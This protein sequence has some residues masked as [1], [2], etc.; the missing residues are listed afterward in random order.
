[1]KYISRILFT[2]GLVF[3][4]T[5][6]TEDALETVGPKLPDNGDMSVNITFALPDAEAQTRSKVS[7]T[8]NRVHTMQMVCFDAN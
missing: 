1:M 4:L 5:A 2:V 3:G 8:E 6:C 7:G